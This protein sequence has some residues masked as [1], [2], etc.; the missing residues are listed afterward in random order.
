MHI[1]SLKKSRIRIHN[2]GTNYKVKQYPVLPT[3][4]GLTVQ[5]EGTANWL[6][7]YG[8]KQM[9]DLILATDTVPCSQEPVRSYTTCAFL[10]RNTFFI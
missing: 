10:F 8:I 2:T 1:F 4:V 5:R 3:R 6:V 9:L 7:R